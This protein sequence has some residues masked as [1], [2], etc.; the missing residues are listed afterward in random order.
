[1]DGTVQESVR[2]RVPH[3]RKQTQTGFPT[4]QVAFT[5][6]VYN[7]N[8]GRWRVI[9]PISSARRRNCPKRCLRSY[10]QHFCMGKNALRCT[11]F[12]FSPDHVD[13]AALK[14][15]R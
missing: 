13:V 6:Y 8:S 10:S 4:G 7:S 14:R 9:E 15:N 2:I 5:Y 1:M 11:V 3:T 12:F